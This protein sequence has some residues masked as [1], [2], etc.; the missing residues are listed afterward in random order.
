MNIV[1]NKR[2]NEN[3]VVKFTQSKQKTLKAKNGNKY[4]KTNIDSE[5]VNLP[6]I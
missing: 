3:S 1:N 4:L 5:K 6:N 2:N